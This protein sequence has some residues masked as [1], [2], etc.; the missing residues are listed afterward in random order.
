M[1][2]LVM[3][4]SGSGKTSVGEA[5]AEQ[6]AC[7]FLE[8]DDMHPPANRR[9]MAAGLPLNDDDRWPWLDAISLKIRENHLHGENLVVACSALKQIYR[10]RLRQ[11][12][13]DL[14]I[15]HLVGSRDLLADRLDA[16]IGHF[17]PPSL[18]DSQLATL[19]P[20]APEE[21]AITID[22]AVPLPE[23]IRQITDRLS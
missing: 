23:L 6:L 4:V 11:G 3:G 8:G 2:V 21:T 13:M 20:P 16:R 5:L 19:E 22:I 17:M 7:D 9:K 10:Q 12:V 1:I 14:R 15:V 18:L